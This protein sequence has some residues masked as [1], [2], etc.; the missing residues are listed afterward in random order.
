MPVIFISQ[1]AF[2]DKKSE[3]FSKQCFRYLEQNASLQTKFRSSYSY[4][5]LK[6]FNDYKG[7]DIERKCFF[8]SYVD[9]PELHCNP[10]YF[11]QI[12]YTEVKAW[13]EEIS[14]KHTCFFDFEGRV[15]ERWEL[16]SD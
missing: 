5:T 7:G 4:W 6:S 3:Y 8:N 9:P 2:A 14:R 10:V 1:F 12:R 11:Q 16:Y 15:L 13:G